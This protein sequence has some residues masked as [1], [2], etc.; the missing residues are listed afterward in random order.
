[1]SKKE[2]N[3]LKKK[4]NK[5]NAKDAVSKGEAPPGKGKPAEKL[6]QLPPVGEGG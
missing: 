4:E 5:A 1:M 3:K 6:G 2:L